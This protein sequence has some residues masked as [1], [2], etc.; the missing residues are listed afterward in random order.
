MA[1]CLKVKKNKYN[2][3]NLIDFLDVIVIFFTK[4]LCQKEEK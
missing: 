3:I 4:R 2:Q 1:L